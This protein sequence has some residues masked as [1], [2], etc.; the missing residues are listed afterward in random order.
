M[1]DFSIYALL[2]LGGFA[3]FVM[4]VWVVVAVA[5]MSSRTDSDDE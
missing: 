2:A 3:C 4:G 5:A 1:P